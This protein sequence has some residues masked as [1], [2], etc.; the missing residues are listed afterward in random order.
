VSG[1][2][3]ERASFTIN[4]AA[5]NLN[6]NGATLYLNRD[7]AVGSIVVIANT[8]GARASGRIVAQ[9]ISGDLYSYGLEFL[10]AGNVKDFW[11]IYF[12]SRSQAQ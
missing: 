4:A 6:R 8:R 3:V 12:P 5:T 2:D 7:I 9:T 1:K 11:G 10:E